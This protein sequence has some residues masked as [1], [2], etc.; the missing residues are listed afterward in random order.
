VAPS[1][2]PEKPSH[3]GASSSPKPA[4]ARRRQSA[5]AK[6][7]EGGDPSIQRRQ[8]RLERNRESARLS[9]RRRKQYLEVLESRVTEFSHEMDKGR[10]EH[11]AKAVVTIQDKRKQLLD[12]G[13][14]DVLA[15]LRVLQT[16]LSRTSSELMVATTFRSQQLNSFALPPSTKFILWLTLQSDAYFR[17]GRAAS[18]RL[19]A[20]RIGER[21]SNP[22]AC[23]GAMKGLI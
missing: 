5:K 20:A 13:M 17:G 23:L 15:K 2:A 9:R 21:V 6:A 8:K 11:V 1:A 10:R 3:G 18:E 22:T 12:S 7:G 19:S 16:T 4:A 14:D